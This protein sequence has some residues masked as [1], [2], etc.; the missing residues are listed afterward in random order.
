M[1]G[2]IGV[3]CATELSARTEG[4]RMDSYF[5]SPR[6]KKAVFESEARWRVA[7]RYRQRDSGQDPAAYLRR[8]EKETS[9]MSEEFNF[10]EAPA[11]MTVKT[12]SPAGYDI[13]L[14]IRDSDTSALMGRMKAALGWLEQNGY[15][16]TANGA[17]SSNGAAP[18]CEFHG[19]MKRSTKFTG[20][21]CPSK[22]HD[23]SY[24][25]ETVKD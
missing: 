17:T 11:S 22:L 7:E 3:A 21:Y 10:G 9:D 6:A 13:L 1:V 5:L 12:I 4:P 20:W 14:T 16:P 24:C 2:S 8:D 23:G 19:P 18:V 15:R 25:N